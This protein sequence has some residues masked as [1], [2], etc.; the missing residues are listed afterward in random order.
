MHS[1]DRRIAVIGAGL[2]GLS[3]ALH[4]QAA[5]LQVDLFEKQDRCGGVVTTQRRNGFLYELGPATLQRGTPA[6]ESILELCNLRDSI[7]APA[8]AA[9]NR[10]IIKNGKLVSLP[11]SPLSFF[12]SKWISAAGKLRLLGEPFIGR[13]QATAQ[14]SVADFVRRRLG[15]QALQYGVDPFV[16]GIYAGNPEQLSLRL[17]FPRLYL[18]EQTGGSLI[19]GFRKLRKQSSGPRIPRGLLS[20]KEGMQQLPDAMRASFK[21]N[22]YTGITVTE[23]S[24]I[25]EAKAESGSQL[26][27]SDSAK[28][29]VKWQEPGNSPVQSQDYAAVIVAGW[30]EDL[31]KL[32][33]PLLETSH[34]NQPSGWPE[35]LYAPV[36]IAVLAYSKDQIQHPLDGFGVLAP[37]SEKLPFLGVIFASSIFPERAPNNQVLLNVFL[38]GIRSPQSAGLSQQEFT[39]QIQPALNRLLGITGSPLWYDTRT[40]K[41]AI[42]QYTFEHEEFLNLRKH[43]ETSHPGLFLAGNSVDGISMPNCLESGLQ[44]AQKVQQQLGLTQ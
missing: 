28:W 21:G 12:T 11:N 7:L 34:G 32:L 42:P 38:G 41:Q 22:V 26:S 35:I 1:K 16:S 6:L 23:I 2:T 29:N 31:K 39:E 33:T 43:L 19:K 30:S 8:Q 40:W 10:Y 20:F 4:L 25:P 18:A 13:G 9:K 14:E 15:Q 27:N 17:A 44:A 36:Q 3:A 5:G 24:R 37:S